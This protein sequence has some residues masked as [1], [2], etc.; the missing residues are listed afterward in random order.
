LRN[1]EHLMSDDI[2]DTFRGAWQADIELSKQ[3]EGATPEQLEQY[4]EVRAEAE[5][6][7]RWYIEKL[8]RDLGILAELMKLPLLAREIQKDRKEWSKK[9]TID[10]EPTGDGSDSKTTAKLHA[11]Y[12]IYRSLT[13]VASAGKLTGLEIF[14]NLL[15]STGK[16]LADSGIEPKNE[17]QVRAEIFRVLKYAFPNDA[18]RENPLT[19]IFKSYHPD[20]AV[21]SLMAVAEYKFVSSE[22]ELKKAI[23]DIYTDMKGYSGHSDWRTFFAVLYSTSSITS[24]DK[25]AAEFRLVRAE[26]NWEPIVVQGPGQRAPKTSTKKK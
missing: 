18:I 11:L 12:K 2:A 20:L 10:L 25:V 9:Q 13:P 5:D 24:A 7:V 23:D 14:R 21:R 15:Q 17:A 4:D 3:H 8:Y 19:K 1:P 16:I 22:D 26:K 6:G